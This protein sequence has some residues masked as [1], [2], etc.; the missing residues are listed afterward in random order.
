M[1]GW[2]SRCGAQMSLSISKLVNFSR[3]RLPVSVVSLTSLLLLNS[4]CFPGWVPDSLD[5]GLTEKCGQLRTSDDVVAAIVRLSIHEEA[6]NSATHLALHVPVYFLPDSEG[7]QRVLLRPGE[8]REPSPPPHCLCSCRIRDAWD[9]GP[10]AADSV[11][12]H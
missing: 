11:H 4:S 12:E 8:R 5:S 3:K 2:T 6:A 9:L 10:R 7:S 1:R